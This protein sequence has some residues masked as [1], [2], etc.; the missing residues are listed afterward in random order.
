M[1]QTCEFRWTAGD[2]QCTWQAKFKV[3]RG[4]EHDAQL[5]CDRHLGR[6]VIALA[7]EEHRAVTVTEVRS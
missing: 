6:T 5:S 7:G 1:A 2:P 4:R 3:A